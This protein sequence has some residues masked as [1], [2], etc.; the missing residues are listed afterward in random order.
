MGFMQNGQR[1]DGHT[2]DSPRGKRWMQTFRKLPINAPNTPAM[3]GIIGGVMT[4]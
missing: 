3:I 2:I 4:E 1:D